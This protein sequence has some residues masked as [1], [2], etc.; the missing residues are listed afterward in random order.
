[1]HLH[2][3]IN[4]HQCFNLTKLLLQRAHVRHYVLISVYPI[5]FV[6]HIFAYR[7]VYFLSTS[8]IYIISF[9]V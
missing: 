1:M 5:Y 9:L 6:S 4:L 8:Q 7:K 2:L 3:D